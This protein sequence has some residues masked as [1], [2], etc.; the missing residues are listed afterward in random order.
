ML[1]IHRIILA[2]AE[3]VDHINGDGLDNRRMNLRAS[4]RAENMRN[5]RKPRNNTS[6]FKGVCWDRD[7]AR[8]R[9][10]IQINGRLLYLGLFD[11]LEVAARAYD[12][13][14]RAHFGAFAA[15]NFPAEG[16]RAAI[17]MAS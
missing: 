11:D 15:L 14:A 4:S 9:S 2:D 13:A 16:E 17:E 1:T 12:T 3:E 8:W 5:T 6:G 10:Y 7:H